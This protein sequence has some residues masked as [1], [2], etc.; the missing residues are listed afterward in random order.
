M[1]LFNRNLCDTNK[2]G[3]LTSEQFALAMWLVERQKE[4]VEPPQVIYYKIKI[5]Y[6]SFIYIFLLLKTLAP[7]MIP[8]SLR[9][10]VGGDMMQ[11]VVS[12]F[13]IYFYVLL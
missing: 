3:K 8:P 2:S 5:L 6:K 4:G 12:F 10:S 13:F 1:F 7:N 9:T 11:Q